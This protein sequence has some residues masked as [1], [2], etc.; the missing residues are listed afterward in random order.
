MQNLVQLSNLLLPAFID[1]ELSSPL[2][3]NYGLPKLSRY[4]NP[5]SI[6]NEY[7]YQYYTASNV[8]GIPPI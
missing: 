8:C 5:I 6:Y 7:L 3:N 2:N 1:Y 4:K